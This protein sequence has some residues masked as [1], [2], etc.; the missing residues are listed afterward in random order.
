MGQKRTYPS[1]PRMSALPPEADCQSREPAAVH[2]TI[3][4]ADPSQLSI[5]PALQCEG[6]PL[7]RQNVWSGFVRLRLA[8]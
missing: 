8:G 3:R 1:Y 6:D 2:I 7:A 5:N 4:C